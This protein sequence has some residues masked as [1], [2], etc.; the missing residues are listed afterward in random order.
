MPGM[1]LKILVKVGD[2]VAKG[3]PLLIL[4]SMKMENVLKAAHNGVVADISAQEGTSVEKN[5]LL[6]RYQ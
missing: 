5:Q 2:Q 4:E 6:L 3:D 1:V